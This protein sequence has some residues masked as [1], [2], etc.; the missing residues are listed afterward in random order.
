MSNRAASKRDS[1]VLLGAALDM[2]VGVGVDVDLYYPNFCFLCCVF[3]LKNLNTRLTR[4]VGS[5]SIVCF[6]TIR[7]HTSFII[8]RLSAPLHTFKTLCRNTCINTAY[9]F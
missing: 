5:T 9:L 6:L 8:L 7:N 4:Y 2:I 1:S 3:Q